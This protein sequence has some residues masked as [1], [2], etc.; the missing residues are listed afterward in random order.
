MGRGAGQ[1]KLPLQGAL[2][3]ALLVAAFARPALAQEGVGS[4]PAIPVPSGIEV[5]W[6]ETL[7][8]TQ[9][10][11]GLTLRFRFVAPQIGA[12][13]GSYDPDKAAADMQA[14]CDSFA[15]ERVPSTGPQPAQLVISLADRLVPFGEIDEEAVQFFEAYSVQDGVCVWELF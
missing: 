13:D 5:H 15:L 6:L 12:A 4:G 8:D 10:P 14:L 1:S 11:A 2:C 7:S 9:G 3:A